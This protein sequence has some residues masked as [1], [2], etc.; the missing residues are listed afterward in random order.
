MINFKLYVAGCLLFTLV[1]CTPKQQDLSQAASNPKI[2]SLKA[3]KVHSKV[4][5]RSQDQGHNVLM[6]WQ[7]NNDKYHIRFYSPFAP[8]S[9]TLEG[10][11]NQVTLTTSD[12]KSY[13][14][15]DPAKLL[16]QHLG[17]SLPFSR[18]N[19]WIKGQ[20]A[21]QSQPTKVIYDKKNHIC[22]LEQDGWKIEYQEYA[23][24]LG[25]DLPVK[26]YLTDGQTIIKLY[27]TDW[28]K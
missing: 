28:K 13:Q 24:S 19:Y 23:K 16:H 9:A 21:P 11:I 17:W 27:V 5:V 26:I 15:D 18:L 25:Q 10:T 6:Q 7:Q 1:S 22:S 4:A 14:S 8:D 3:W 2:S 20:V 12:G